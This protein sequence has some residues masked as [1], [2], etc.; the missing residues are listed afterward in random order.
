MRQDQLIKV[1]QIILKDNP[2]AVQ[3]GSL[4]FTLQ[5]IRLPRVPEDIDIYIPF[6]ERFIPLEGAELQDVILYLYNSWE[7]TEAEKNKKISFNYSG[8]YNDNPSE[9][10]V[11]VFHPNTRLASE[12]TTVHYDGFLCEHY[13]NILMYKVIHALSGNTKHKNDLM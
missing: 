4:A 5:N 10:K 2:N 12:V 13:S 6:S 7:E 9:L 1:S 11:D 8:I 3:S